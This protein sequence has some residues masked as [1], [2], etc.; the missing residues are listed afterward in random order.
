MLIIWALDMLIQQIYGNDECEILF[1]KVL[2]QYPEIRKD[3][4]IQTKCGIRDGFYDFSLGVQTKTW[5][6]QKGQV[7]TKQKKLKKH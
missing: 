2:K 6:K 3:L 7:C 1:G 4:I 5:T